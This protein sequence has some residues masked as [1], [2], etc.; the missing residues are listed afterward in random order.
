MVMSILLVHKF[1]KAP[2]GNCTFWKQCIET[3]ELYLTNGWLD[4]ATLEELLPSIACDRGEPYD[5]YVH[6]REARRKVDRAS[7]EYFAHVCNTPI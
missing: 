3:V 1:R 5:T 7:C 2:Y 4:D 6:N